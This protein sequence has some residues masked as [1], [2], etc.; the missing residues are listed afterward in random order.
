M[1]RKLILLTVTFLLAVMGAG[2]G[3]ASANDTDYLRARAWERHEE[4]IHGLL[5]CFKKD[6]APL[7]YGEHLRE[8]V[9]AEL[10]LYSYG[11]S[12]TD[13]RLVVHLADGMKSVADM[14]VYAYRIFKK[15]LINNQSGFTPKP[16]GSFEGETFRIISRKDTSQRFTADFK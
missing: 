12:P 4:G 8:I 2:A 7:K 11:I 14:P 5:A 13:P 10:A 6:C 3:T 1:K 15:R 16:E 9:S